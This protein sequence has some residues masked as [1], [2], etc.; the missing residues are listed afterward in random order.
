MAYHTQTNYMIII[1]FKLISSWW[2]LTPLFNSSDMIALCLFRRQFFT[3]RRTPLTS[4]HV[5]IR[6]NV[7]CIL[8]PSDFLSTLYSVPIDGATVLSGILNY[9]NYFPRARTPCPRVDPILKWATGQST[10]II[11]TT[12]TS[13]F[14]LFLGWRDGGWRRGWGRN[15][16]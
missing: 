13:R 6:C 5:T 16:L 15:L 9:T 12:G 8:Q 2:H 14:L 11:Y 7:S 4:F 3:H 10:R 1:S